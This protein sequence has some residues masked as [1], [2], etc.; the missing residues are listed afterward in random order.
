MLDT[1]DV[2]SRDYGFASKSSLS[3]RQCL[4]NWSWYD[5]LMAVRVVQLVIAVDLPLDMSCEHTLSKAG[6]RVIRGETRYFMCAPC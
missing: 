3:R 6:S 5:P 2:W 1:G 4:V